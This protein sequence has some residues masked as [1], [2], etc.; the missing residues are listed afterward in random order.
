MSTSI[1][2]IC[3][4]PPPQLLRQGLAELNSGL[5]FECHE[6]LETIWKQYPKDAPQRDLFKGIL[7][8]AVGLY[9]DRDGKRNP[10]LRKFQRAMELLVPYAPSCMGVDVEAL[11]N[12]C[13]E[14]LEFLQAQPEGVMV[15]HSMLPII[16]IPDAPAPPQA[17]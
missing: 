16:P 6:T 14:M 9:H 1:Q 2:E 3:E 17:D 8:I 15:P 13:R 12:A 5:W 11:L 10:P 4:Q 7:Q